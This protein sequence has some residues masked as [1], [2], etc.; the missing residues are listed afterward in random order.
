[1]PPLS[2]LSALSRVPCFAGFL[3]SAADGGYGSCGDVGSELQWAG[4]CELAG[5]CGG[6]D[7]SSCGFTSDGVDSCGSGFWLAVCTAVHVRPILSLR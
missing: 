6:S 1:M 7:G 3:Y 4:S 5:R 2:M